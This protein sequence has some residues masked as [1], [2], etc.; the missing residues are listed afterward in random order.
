MESREAVFEY[1]WVLLIAAVVVG[2]SASMA[3]YGF[4]RGLNP[5]CEAYTLEE[6]RKAGISLEPGVREVGPGIYEVTIEAR[7]FVFIPREIVLKDPSRV[8]FRVYSQDVIHGLSIVGTSVNIM[9]LPGYVAEFVW[10]PPKAAKGEFLV[11]CTEYCG[12]GHQL[13]YSKLVIERAS[14]H[15]AGG[16]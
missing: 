1:I 15:M 11:I 4:A 6:A 10:E 14:T 8:T 7:Q 2:L 12:I 3:Y 13:M 16:G 9:V 5:T